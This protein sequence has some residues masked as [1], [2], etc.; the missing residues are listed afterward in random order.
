MLALLTI[1][2][3]KRVVRLSISCRTERQKIQG[4]A[5]HGAAEK[6]EIKM[7]TRKDIDDLFALLKIFRPKDRHLKDLRL[8]EA[9]RLVLEP[10]NKDDVRDAIG[11]YFRESS[12]WPDVTEIAVRCPLL[13]KEDRRKKHSSAV[14]SEGHI[15]KDPLWIRWA[16]LVE[17]R[18]KAGVPVNIQETNEAGL[19]DG[20]WFE[21][22]EKLGLNFE[23]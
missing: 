18:R 10:Y 20:T 1:R 4:E 6:R 3:A 12:F 8:R 19:S 9:W 11:M 23:I 13:P 7:L 2:K 14:L 17:Q 22:L 21:M 16:A 5:Y 15:S